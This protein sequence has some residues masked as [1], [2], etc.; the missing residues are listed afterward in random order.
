MDKKFSHASLPCRIAL[1]LLI[2]LWVTPGLFAQLPRHAIGLRYGAAYGLS[3]DV[4]IV[5]NLTLDSTVIT[6]T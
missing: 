1:P 3:T 2:L 6:N 5:W 4:S